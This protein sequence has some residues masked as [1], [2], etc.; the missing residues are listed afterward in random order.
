MHICQAASDP[1]L[2]ACL[3]VPAGAKTPLS[4]FVTAWVVGFVLIW[5]TPVFAHLPY[6]V[7]GAVVVSSVLSLFEYE[8]AIYLFRVRH[9]WAEYWLQVGFLV[10]C[11]LVGWSAGWFVG[12]LV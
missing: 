5:L 9:W 7:L 11:R 8:L 2:S 1:R 3:N 12:C 4:Q 6:N 10:S